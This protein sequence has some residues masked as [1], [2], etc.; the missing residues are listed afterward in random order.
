LL[1]GN[2]YAKIINLKCIDDDTKSTLHPK[3][4][5]EK[6]TAL[7]GESKYRIFIGENHYSLTDIREGD[8]FYI[9][10]ITGGYNGT[11]SKKIWTKG[12]CYKD[13]KMK[14]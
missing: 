8:T 6:K 1:C 13:P 12:T 5:T 9:N 2:N 14:F 7:I 4:D 11:M 10:R 3:L